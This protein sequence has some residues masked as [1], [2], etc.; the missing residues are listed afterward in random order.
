MTNLRHAISRLMLPAHRFWRCSAPARA[1]HGAG[2]LASS[3]A[4]KQPCRLPD[5]AQ[6]SWEELRREFAEIDRELYP[7][8]RLSLLW[9]LTPLLAMLVL[10]GVFAALASGAP[11]PK[12]RI[13]KP[14][15]PIQLT[16]GDWNLAWG[17]MVE[18]MPLTKEGNYGWGK[19]W[20]GSW[21]WDSKSRILIVHEIGNGNVWLTWF[22]V[23]DSQG[24]GKVAEGEFEGVTIRVWRTPAKRPAANK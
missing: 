14:P 12:P 15:P 6:V 8:R 4:C 22:V 24:K 11:Q 3:G 19:D 1:G 2:H 13:A 21:G 7:P 16:A 20:K 18:D 5:A 23:L 17:G 9:V 10:L